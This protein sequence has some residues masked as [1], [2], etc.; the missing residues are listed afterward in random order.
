MGSD[1]AES[2]VPE[3]NRVFIGSRHRASCTACS[4]TTVVD[5]DINIGNHLHVLS[6]A[7]LYLRIVGTRING[8]VERDAT[9]VVETLSYIR[10]LLEQIV[11][12]AESVFVPSQDDGFMTY[13]TPV[14]GAVELLLAADMRWDPDH[15]ALYHIN[16]ANDEGAP[17]SRWV[18]KKAAACYRLVSE[19]LELLS[20]GRRRHTASVYADIDRHTEEF[21]ALADQ[22]QRPDSFP[23][24][25]DALAWMRLRNFFATAGCIVRD[26]HIAEQFQSYAEQ[27]VRYIERVLSYLEL[28]NYSSAYRPSSGNVFSTC[29]LSEDLQMAKYLQAHR[30]S[31]EGGSRS[32]EHTGDG[33]PPRKRE[34][35]QACTPLEHSL[36]PQSPDVRS[37]GVTLIRTPNPID[38]RHAFMMALPKSPS[39]FMREP[40]SQY[41]GLLNVVQNCFM[42]SLLQA[43]FTCRKFTHTMLQFP[44]G[45]AERDGPR[46]GVRHVDPCAGVEAVSVAGAAPT[47]QE[48]VIQRLQA[49]FS[50]LEMSAASCVNPEYVLEAVGAANPAFL[51]GGQHDPQEFADAFI[52]MVCEGFGTL[53][54][55]G[56]AGAQHRDLVNALE[57]LVY[58]ETVEKSVDRAT[59][60]VSAEGRVYRTLHFI[61]LCLPAVGEPPRGDLA[62]T[63]YLPQTP[64]VGATEDARHILANYTLSP[65]TQW[66]TPQDTPTK[67]GVCSERENSV[68]MGTG[69]V[70]IPSSYP[71]TLEK[72][73]DG[74]DDV[75][76][77]SSPEMGAQPLQFD[78]RCMVSLYSALDQAAIDFHDAASSSQATLKSFRTLPKLLMFFLPGRTMEGPMQET[79]QLCYD[80]VLYLDRYVDQESANAARDECRQSL[81]ERGRIEEEIKEA[82]GCLAS[83]KAFLRVGDGAAEKEGEAAPQFT[84]RHQAVLE[85]VLAEQQEALRSLQD[86]LAAEEARIRA[87]YEGVGRN[88]QNTYHLHAVIVHKKLGENCGHYFSYALDTRRRSASKKPQWIKF[89]DTRVT[90]VPES[91]V[92]SEETRQN[93]YCLFYESQESVEEGK[94]LQIEVPQPLARIIEHE[95][96][97]WKG[98]VQRRTG[99]AAEAAPEDLAALPEAVAP[100]ARGVRED[101]AAAGVGEDGIILMP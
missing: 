29:F 19:E 48:K 75:A 90:N 35:S 88:P 55:E 12:G 27:A 77:G 69:F 38:K 82:K 97:R 68:P 80:S 76:G 60:K 93:A 84:A 28:C 70:P 43:Y 92:F 40:Q 2:A 13:V 17:R 98:K 34:G 101:P 86:D 4:A 45:W 1:M 6:K 99:A 83:M 89:D 49:V 16:I 74:E 32:P 63:P 9:E 14:I 50:Y 24:F 21:H 54:K 26:G 100:K 56:G 8:T 3:W 5:A 20:Q 10:A 71:D 85:G 67:E 22:Y 46:R 33:A 52:D 31:Y 41:A 11:N 30:S 36:S 7:E 42:N 15:S 72:N 65:A 53:A 73:A 96:Q 81:V 25:D 18:S 94:R 62:G 23:T 79:R 61:P 87:S 78:D 39:C 44:S 57:D 64:P 37:P 95:D 47:P 59:E 66:S 91:E 51:D 58:G